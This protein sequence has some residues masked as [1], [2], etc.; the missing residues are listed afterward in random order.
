MY[1][2]FYIDKVARFSRIILVS[3]FS[4]FVL[5]QPLQVSALAGF[6]EQVYRYEY[7]PGLR[8]NIG[9]PSDMCPSEYGNQRCMWVE[10]TSYPST[11]TIPYF[12]SPTFLS[13]S[14]LFNGYI[15]GQTYK[16]KQWILISIKSDETVYMASSESELIAKMKELGG[17]DKLYDLK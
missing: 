17:V 10:P 2:Q 1:K 3:L 7:S 14:E 13:V 15:A 16:D 6:A 8:L 4:F 12:V 11:S 5:L 9:A